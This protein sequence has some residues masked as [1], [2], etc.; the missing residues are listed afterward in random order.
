[1]RKQTGYEDDWIN[2]LNAAGNLANT[3]SQTSAK[4]L[5]TEAYQKD[6]N[7]KRRKE[8]IAN[9]MTT[10]L[11]RGVS[12][13]ELAKTTSVPGAGAGW[14]EDYQKVN[15]G[16]KPGDKDYVP[17]TGFTRS[18][19][20]VGSAEVQAG[21]N[22][23]MQRNIDAYKADF[24]MKKN[25]VAPIIKSLPMDKLN[26]LDFEQFGD[27]AEAA[28]AVFAE[29]IK[30]RSD[31]AQYKKQFDDAIRDGIAQHWKGWSSSV[32]LA[33]ESIKKGNRVAAM[34][35][36]DTAINVHNSDSR[37]FEVNPN[38][39]T[40]GKFYII[41]EGKKTYD[42]KEYEVEDVL[43]MMKEIT[44]QQ[45][46][47]HNWAAAKESQTFNGASAN[48]PVMLFN[49]K[50]GKTLSAVA[51]KDP[52]TSAM[53]WVV[54]DKGK[55]IYRGD[56][57]KIYDLGYVSSK[58][59]EEIDANT[60]RGLAIQGDRVSIE[61]ARKEG[62]IR[63]E[64]LKAAKKKG[65]EEKNF[66]I[67][68]DNRREATK[69]LTQDLWANGINVSYDQ[70]TGDM[71][72]TPGT[73]LTQE[74]RDRADAIASKHG[75][76]A[77]F[78]KTEDGIDNGWFRDNTP[79]YELGGVTMIRSGNDKSMGLQRKPAPSESG[80]SMS[81]EEFG[82]A[83][84]G[85][86]PKSKDAE[87]GRGLVERAYN[88]VVPAGS[89]ADTVVKKGLAPIPGQAKH[90]AK[91][92][93]EDG[94]KPIPG[95]AAKV[96]KTVIKPFTAQYSAL[97]KVAKLQVLKNQLSHAESASERKQLEAEINALKS[98]K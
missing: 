5:Q 91:V 51:E 69:A 8:A 68:R 98:K 40:S 71:K 35:Y 7:D 4:G 22:D 31:S 67:I 26:T 6:L 89:M 75:F 36:A 78:R 11:S 64:Q 56:L 13:D 15:A 92:V 84:T 23:A 94:L 52:I 29:D 21:L 27:S 81:R 16:L 80:M 24:E 30:T 73:I 9:A 18:S 95:Q 97:S 76:S 72:V 28:R 42:G 87:H 39:G 41:Q 34:A 33:D 54:H 50:T 14:Q 88:S 66:Q 1:M 74:Q 59:K 44:P 19:D 45:F 82:A 60:R 61:N 12:P 90:V 38:T 93:Y 10:G 20:A 63:D 96:A 83:I 53:T 62:A 85:E 17:E 57:Q 2:T 86:K 65:Q 3:L 49:E 25:K 58:G 55:P 32:G 47:E 43:K 70:D 48:N 46:N 77:A 79:G 37:K